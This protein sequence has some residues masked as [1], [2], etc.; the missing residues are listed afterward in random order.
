MSTPV[1][2]GWSWT[3]FYPVMMWFDNILV[4][5]E[6]KK[7]KKIRKGER[8]AQTAALEKYTLMLSHPHPHIYTLY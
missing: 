3:F 6:K 8:K 5:G 7:R 2:R 4:L 1:L